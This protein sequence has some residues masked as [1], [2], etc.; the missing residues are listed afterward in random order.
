MKKFPTLTDRDKEGL[1]DLIS[2]TEDFISL[3]F[4]W[5]APLN[6]RHMLGELYDFKRQAE[7]ALNELG[8]E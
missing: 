8:A 2:K 4:D 1:E 7:D 5:V 3:V 6:Q